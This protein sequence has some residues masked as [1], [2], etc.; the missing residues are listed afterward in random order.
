MKILFWT[1]L[2]DNL[3]MV[4]NSSHLGKTLLTLLVRS[5][6]Y[7]MASI[8]WAPDMQTIVSIRSGFQSMDTFISTIWT[9]PW[10]HRERDEG[11]YNWQFYEKGFASWATAFLPREV[12]TSKVSTCRNNIQWPFLNGQCWVSSAV[13]QGSAFMPLS[14]EC[15]ASGCTRDSCEVGIWW[16]ATI[17]LSFLEMT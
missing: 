16:G 15:K 7:K 13:G 12:W 4:I 3:Y 6:T 1:D 11:K 10:L 2:E 9:S 8:Y 14:L 5:Y 17:T